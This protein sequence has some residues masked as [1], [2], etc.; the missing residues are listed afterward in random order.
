MTVKIRTLKLRTLHHMTQQQLAR[1]AK[2]SKTT[3]SNLE[4][5]HQTKIELETIAK[6]CKALDC[7]P[8]E[9]F[10]FA[11]NQLLGSQKAALDPFVGSLEY[12]RSFHPEKLDSE[13]ARMTD[14][15]KRRSKL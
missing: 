5:G 13:L 3:I 4:S 10:E 9:L 11:E 2:L 8:S 14:T 12:D 15:K 6:L 1:R 7:T